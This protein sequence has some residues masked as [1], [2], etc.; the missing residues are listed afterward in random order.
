MKTALAF[1]VLVIAA[2]LM[3][4]VLLGSTNALALTDSVST[5]NSPLRSQAEAEAFVDWMCQA[6][7]FPVAIA[8]YP[9]NA[10]FDKS[11]TGTGHLTYN[12]NLVWRS[13]ERGDTRAMAITGYPT[14]ADNGLATCPVA[15]WYHDGDNNTHD[16]VKY[17]G[18]DLGRMQGYA[19]LICPWG[20][21]ETWHSPGSLRR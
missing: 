6:S 3:A 2:S 9:S 5:N 16:C 11:P 4:G 1:F 18:S 8:A 20:S 7:T 12:A 17:T 15:G 10:T 14:T 19:E 21:G 13:C